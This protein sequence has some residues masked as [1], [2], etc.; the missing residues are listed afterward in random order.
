[1]AADAFALTSV[2]KRPN[3]F[4][5][6][7]VGLGDFRNPRLVKKMARRQGDLKRFFEGGARGRLWVVGLGEFRPG[8]GRRRAGGGI[9][10]L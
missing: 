6:N 4:L 8:G 7:F 5:E 2:F 9:C 3:H 10:Q 1:M